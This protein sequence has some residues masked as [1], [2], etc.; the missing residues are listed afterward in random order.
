MKTSSELV[1]I[2]LAASN[3]KAQLTLVNVKMKT[4]QE[5]IQ[6][7]LA[8]RGCVVFDFVE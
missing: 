1:K 7:A 3:Q 2:A 4:T 6:I 8:G 5:L